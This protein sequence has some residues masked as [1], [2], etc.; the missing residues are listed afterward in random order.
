MSSS[1]ET[2]T[3]SLIETAFAYYFHRTDRLLRLH[4][5]KLMTDHKE[6]ITVEQWLLLNQLSVTGSAYQTDLVDKTFKDRPNVTRLLDGLEKKDLVQ[7]E[8]D[9][10]DRRKF[11]V[12][13]TKKGKALLERTVPRMLK[14]RKLIYKGLSPSDLQTLKRISETIEANVL[15]GRI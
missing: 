11:K 15:D 6:D 5:T 8:D 12:V 7:R 14:E 2:K 10:E 4:F 3:S 13:I 9:S 1:K